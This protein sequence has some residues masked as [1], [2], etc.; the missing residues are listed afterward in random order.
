MFLAGGRV[1]F[2]IFALLCCFLFAGVVLAA[3][4]ASSTPAAPPKARVEVVEEIFQWPYDLGFLP[5][6]GGFG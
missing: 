5:V 2:W 1:L 6:V 3:D 4:G